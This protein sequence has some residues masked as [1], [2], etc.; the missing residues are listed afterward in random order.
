MY[1]VKYFKSGSASALKLPVSLGENRRFLES[2]GIR[3]SKLCRQKNI[4]KVYIQFVCPT[5]SIFDNN[6]S[7][8]LSQRKSLGV[9][10]IWSPMSQST[11]NFF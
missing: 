1:I 9:S 11:I 4:E 2:L 6:P 7:K 5:K 3:Q 8:F 10:V